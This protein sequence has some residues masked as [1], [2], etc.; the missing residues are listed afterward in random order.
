MTDNEGLELSL[1]IE[2]N[3]LARE[4]YY[5]RKRQELSSSEDNATATAKRQLTSTA[6][7][8]WKDAEAALWRY[9]ATHE[10]TARPPHPVRGLFASRQRSALLS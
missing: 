4:T 8:A 7:H 5:H 2:G 3:W 10:T 9:R 6:D 1:L